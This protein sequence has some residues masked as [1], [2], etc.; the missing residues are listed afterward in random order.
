[1]KVEF[2]YCILKKGVQTDECYAFVEIEG[3]EVLEIMDELMEVNSDGKLTDIPEKYLKRFVNAALEDAILIY[4]NF[5]DE[6]EEY[7][8][9]LQ[10][11]LPEDLLNVLPDELM[12]S[13]SPDMFE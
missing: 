7:S 11:W 3:E 13:F 10:R 5:D 9:M 8:I 6:Q 12:Y 2:N 4:P 1:M